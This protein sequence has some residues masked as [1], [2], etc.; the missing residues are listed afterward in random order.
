MADKIFV[1]G[2]RTSKPHDNAPDF[3]KANI[4]IQR[5]TLIAWLTNQ[6]DEWINAQILD[7][8]NKPGTW[9]VEVD[10]WK[11]KSE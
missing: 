10:T 7:S 6:T 1:D 9:Y 5:E 8:K 11:P 4:S 3:V 2:L